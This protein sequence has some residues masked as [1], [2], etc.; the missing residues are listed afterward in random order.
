LVWR[1]NKAPHRAEFTP[2]DRVGTLTRRDDA[3]ARTAV[4]SLQDGPIQQLGPA[5]AAIYA[6]SANPVGQVVV[7]QSARPA[8]AEDLDALK[9][10]VGRAQAFGEWRWVAAGKTGGQ[11]TCAQVAGAA[12]DVVCIWADDAGSGMATF[13]KRPLGESVALLNRIRAAG[14]S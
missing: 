10:Q 2:P 14:A 7:F 8:S 1:D 5:H 12:I 13:A 4:S 3:A 9:I 11:V 6:D